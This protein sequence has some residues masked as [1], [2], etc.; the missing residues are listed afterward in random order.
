MEKA[1]WGAS[2]AD[3]DPRSTALVH[4]PKPAFLA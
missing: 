4:G 1:L 2:I 3:A